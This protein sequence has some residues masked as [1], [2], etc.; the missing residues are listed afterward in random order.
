MSIHVCDKTRTVKHILTYLTQLSK[1]SYK[2]LVNRLGVQIR[3]TLVASVLKKNLALGYSTAKSGAALTI[4]GT[5][6]DSAITN[7]EQIHDVWISVLEMA[8][9]LYLLS[10]LVGHAFFLPIITITGKSLQGELL[11]SS[12]NI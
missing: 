4:M 3:G 8:A 6:V 12:T 2:H 11:T 5:D 10:R 9:A 7:T 1:T